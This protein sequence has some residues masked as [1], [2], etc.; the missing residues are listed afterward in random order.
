M[1][2]GPGAAVGGMQIEIKTGY[3]CY[4]ICYN[5]KHKMALKQSITVT[6]NLFLTDPKISKSAITQWFLGSLYRAVLVFRCFKSVKCWNF[7][8]RSFSNLEHLLHRTRPK[9]A[10]TSSDVPKPRR[11]DSD[12]AIHHRYWG[13][14]HKNTIRQGNLALQTYKFFAGMGQ[15]PI[16]TKVDGYADD[17]TLVL[18]RIEWAITAAMRAANPFPALKSTR[19]KPKC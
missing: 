12:H 16:E 11:P 6:S 17:L 10:L 19:I 5:S 13:A 8:F 14:P 3:S 1:D 9:H 15:S 7:A 18:P 4:L 2:L